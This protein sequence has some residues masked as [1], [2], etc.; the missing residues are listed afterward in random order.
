MNIAN[1]IPIIISVVLVYISLKIQEEGK[2]ELQEEIRQLNEV[3]ADQEREL[4]ELKRI[5][6]YY[7]EKAEG[8]VGE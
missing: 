6:M 2:V 7:Q 3:I 8:R 4:T 1:S 5:A